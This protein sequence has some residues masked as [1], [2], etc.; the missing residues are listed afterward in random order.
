MPPVSLRTPPANQTT[1]RT[2]SGGT[3]MAT[4]I[5]TMKTITRANGRRIQ[6]IDVINVGLLPVSQPFLTARYSERYPWEAL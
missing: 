3:T 4:K 2:I 5:T 1:I 6:I